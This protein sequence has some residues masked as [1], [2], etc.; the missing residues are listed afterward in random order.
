MVTLYRFIKKTKETLVRFSC[1]ADELEEIQQI[2]GFLPPKAELETDYEK[3]YY[4]YLRGSSRLEKETRLREYFK[5]RYSPPPVELMIFRGSTSLSKDYTRHEW[6]QRISTSICNLFIERKYVVIA[7]KNGYEIYRNPEGRSKLTQDVD[8]LVGVE[9]RVVVPPDYIPLLYLDVVY[10]LEYKRQEIS[11]KQLAKLGLPS[12]KQIFEQYSAFTSRNTDTLFRL[13]SRFMAALPPSICDT[14]C[15]FERSP[16]SPTSLGLETWLWSHELNLA[17]ELGQGCK[18]SLAKSIFDEGI[19]LYSPPQTGVILILVFPSETRDVPFGTLNLLEEISTYI[20]DL[21]LINPLIEKLPYSLDEEIETINEKCRSLLD[22]YLELTPIFLLVDLSKENFDGVAVDTNDFNKRLSQSLRKQRRGAYLINLNL[23]LSMPTRERKWLIESV[24]VKSLAAIG[25][26]P[27]RVLNIPS[28]ENCSQ[29]EIC[30]IGIDINA[31]FRKLKP[32]I[33]GVILDGYGVLTGF[34]QVGI[35]EPHGEEVSEEEFKL[36]IE[37]LLHHHASVKGKMPRHI[38]I[39]RDGLSKPR[40]QKVVSEMRAI[41]LSVDLLEIRKHGCPRLCQPMN[42]QATP[43]QDIALGSERLGLVYMYN[44]RV[45]RKYDSKKQSVFPNP[46]GITIRRVVGNTSIRILASQV[47]A[48]TLANY[49]SIRMTNRLPS[50]IV[51]ADA[52]VDKVQL[53]D[54]QQDSGKAITQPTTIY[55]L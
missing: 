51:Y 38:V 4:A 42:E 15:S 19:E 20:K 27:W 14:N 10:R 55:W 8:V 12:D 54:W 53:K 48:L 33:G 45:I 3:G 2:L 40:E 5:S 47:Y 7:G 23:Q 24:L 41:G 49:S 52:L 44:T 6:T 17:L 50:T 13:A 31:T 16:S 22:K 26:I 36:L 11:V 43:S 30:F 46:Q 34:H 32:I 1:S 18:V 28:L 25:A 37:Q 21:G 35:S 9:F 29:E 39:H